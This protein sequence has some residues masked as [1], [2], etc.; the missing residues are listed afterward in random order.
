[1]NWRDAFELASF[2][3][4]VVGLPFAIGVFL[5]QQRQE[6]ENE[7]EAA[8]QQLSDAY[9]EFLKIVLANADLQLRT[10]GALPNPTPEQ[11]ERMMVIFDMLVSLFERAYLV[12]YKDDMTPTERRRWNSWDDYMREWCRRDDFHNALPLLLRGEDP[13]FQTYIKRVSGEERGTPLVSTY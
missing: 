7:D 11:N 1:V 6:R 13:G 4:T 12:A 5:L 8:Y 2:V 3:V 9:T 10:S